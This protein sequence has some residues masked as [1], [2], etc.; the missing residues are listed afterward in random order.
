MENK[1]I[2]PIPTTLEEA[3]DLQDFG[4]LVLGEEEVQ[5]RSEL[6]AT[7]VGRPLSVENALPVLRGM[8][9]AIKSGSESPNFDKAKAYLGQMGLSETVNEG[10]APTLAGVS[11]LSA[12]QPREIALAA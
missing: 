7:V 10:P 9:E 8:R 6:A 1:G 2:R 3:S 12:E 5:R 4:V 11:Y